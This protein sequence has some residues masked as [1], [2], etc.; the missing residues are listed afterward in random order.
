MTGIDPT[1]TYSFTLRITKHRRLVEIERI[2]SRW[3]KWFKNYCG[4]PDSFNLPLFENTNVMI[5]Q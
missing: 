5:A 2:S 4:I 3:K 1:E